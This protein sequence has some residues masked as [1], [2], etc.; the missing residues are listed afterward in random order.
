MAS[1]AK[2]RGTAIMIAI[3]MTDWF[4]N[5][6]VGGELIIGE[7]VSISFCANS[8]SITRY[9]YLKIHLFSLK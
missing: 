4:V 9:L 2:V 1:V 7:Q 5:S 3:V 8:S 6:M